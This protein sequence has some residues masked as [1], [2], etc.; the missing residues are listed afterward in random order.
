MK[1]SYIIMGILICIIAF[2]GYLQFYKQ[3]FDVI[4]NKLFILDK[5]KYA[6]EL[7]EKAVK[8]K[9]R[10]VRFSYDITGKPNEMIISVYNTEWHYQYNCMAL[11]IVYTSDDGKLEIKNCG[12]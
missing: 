11:Q 2:L 10:N 6:E 4:A 9:Y 7:I 1:K 8:N 5:E 12:E 3:E